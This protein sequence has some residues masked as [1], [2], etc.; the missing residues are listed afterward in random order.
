MNISVLSQINDE[1]ST[2]FEYDATGS[3]DT[4]SDCALY[5]YVTVFRVTLFCY[6]NE[7]VIGKTNGY[8][9]YK[10]SEFCIFCIT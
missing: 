2:R 6:A 7:T 1:K 4:I 9:Y 3:Q 5:R 8:H 10:R